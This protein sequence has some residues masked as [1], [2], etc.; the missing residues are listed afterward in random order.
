MEI[1][2]RVAEKVNYLNYTPFKIINAHTVNAM[3]PFFGGKRMI[4]SSNH[5]KIIM[6]F[7][8]IND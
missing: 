8:T 2:K 3:K 7:F 5:F 1:V 4:Y 6:R